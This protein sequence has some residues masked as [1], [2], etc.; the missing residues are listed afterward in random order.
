MMWSYFYYQ[1]AH[2][3]YSKIDNDDFTEKDMFD[4]VNIAL[5]SWPQ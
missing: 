2:S 3:F 1:I 4:K 5:Q